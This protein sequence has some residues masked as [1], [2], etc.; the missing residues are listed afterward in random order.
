MWHRCLGPAV[1]VVSKHDLGKG[2]WQTVKWVLRYLLKI[3]DVGLVFERND[4]CDWYAIDFVDLYCVSDLDKRQ[5]TTGYVFTLSVSG[6]PV[7]WKSTKHINVRYQFMR[8]LLVND[9]S[10]FRR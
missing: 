10:Y 3:V 9:E 8:R 7:S 5:L 1:E 4:T 6:A 2:H